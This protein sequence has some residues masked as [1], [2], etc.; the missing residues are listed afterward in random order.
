[1]NASGNRLDDSIKPSGGGTYIVV[2][3]ISKFEKT[4]DS[5]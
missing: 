3:S 4:P 1:L 2:P 5:F